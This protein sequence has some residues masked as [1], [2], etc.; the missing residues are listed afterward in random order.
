MARGEDTSRH[1]NR[2]VDAGK[3]IVHIEDTDEP[4]EMDASRLIEYGKNM[5]RANAGDGV[6]HSASRVRTIHH[7]IQNAVWGGDIVIDPSGKRHGD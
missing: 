3:F 7:A 5:A 6:P 2:R 4:E 1:P